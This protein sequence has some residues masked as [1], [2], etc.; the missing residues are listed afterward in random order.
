M[1]YLHLE[2]GRTK[3]GRLTVYEKYMYKKIQKIIKYKKKKT[4]MDKK[5]IKYKKKKKRSW[6]M[7][8]PPD[9]SHSK[10]ESFSMCTLYFRHMYT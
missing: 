9:E 6:K 5:I 3:N 4:V 8:L 7:A 2:S 10:N 1:H